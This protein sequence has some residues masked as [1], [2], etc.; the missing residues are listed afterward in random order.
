MNF[1]CE[2]SSVYVLSKKHKTVP[3]QQNYN[4][5]VHWTKTLEQ[6]SKDIKGFDSH[7]D[8]VDSKSALF[9]RARFSEL[10]C[11]YK[12]T[13]ILLQNRQDQVGEY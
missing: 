6:I 3:A 1:F 2:S 13:G 10:S 11:N 4:G 8:A 7:R 12:K 5:E 9:S